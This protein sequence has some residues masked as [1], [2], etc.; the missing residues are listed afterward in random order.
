M[1]YIQ[2]IYPHDRLVIL[3]RRINAPARHYVLIYVDPMKRGI[4][5]IYLIPFHPGRNGILRTI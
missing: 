1:L 3:L 5:C 2:I 4:L